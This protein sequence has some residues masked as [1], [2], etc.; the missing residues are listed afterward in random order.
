M[1][2]KKSSQSDG[3]AQVWRKN[4]SA[5]DPKPSTLSDKH[6]RGGLMAWVCRAASGTGT[7]IFIDNVTNGDSSRINLKSLQKPFV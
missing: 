7:I 3:N 6:D 5:H 1:S 2:H 4:S